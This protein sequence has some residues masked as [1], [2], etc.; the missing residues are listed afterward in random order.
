[1]P[2]ITERDNWFIFYVLIWLYLFIKG[3]RRGKVAAL[4][5]LLLIL[6][7]DQFAN[8][9]LKPLFQRVRPCHILPNVHLLINCSDSYAFPS[10]HAVNNF[11]AA[12]LF[13]NFYPAM[14]YFLFSGAFLVAISR[15]MCG[16][17]YPFDIFGGAIFGILYAWI[18][19]YLWKAI[20]RKLNFLPN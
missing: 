3:G 8:N 2:F 9:I 13:S 19:I 7:S 20:N 5:I 17:H 6:F 16:V 11:A 15:V 1:M 10:N 14:K 4:L 12:T 18:I